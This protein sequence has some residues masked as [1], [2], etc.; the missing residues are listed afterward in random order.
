MY[1]DFGREAVEKLVQKY[2]ITELDA[3]AWIPEKS[4]KSQLQEFVQ[5]KWK[6]IPVYKDR[7]LA[8]EDSGNVTLYGADVYIL[9]AL[10]ARGIGPSKKK[11]Q[12]D[13]AGKAMQKITEEMKKI[14]E[15][16]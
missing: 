11:A 14:W 1:L 8:V 16:E 7:E 13:G 15:E 4:W 12:E 10:K 5:K 6:E 9:W 2:I 3:L